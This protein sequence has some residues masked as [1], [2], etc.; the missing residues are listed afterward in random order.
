VL[1]AASWGWKSWP[2]TPQVIGPGVYCLARIQNDRDGWQPQ[3]TL[4]RSP[5]F[6]VGCFPSPSCPSPWPWP[7]SSPRRRKVS[8]YSRM[9]AP[10]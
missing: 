7:P 5:V 10:R 6:S 1:L 4:N 2:Q 9:A 3:D 8:R